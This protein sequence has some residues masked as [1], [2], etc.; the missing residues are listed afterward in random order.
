[1]SIRGKAAIVG[2]GELAPERYSRGETGLSLLSRVASLALTDAGLGP[3]DI[4]GL[5]IHPLGGI[6]ALAPSTMVELLGLR[7]RFA[8]IIDLGGATRTRLRLAAAPA[9]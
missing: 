9:I 4:D 6:A 3:P 1:M 8:A 7:A 5:V 2:I